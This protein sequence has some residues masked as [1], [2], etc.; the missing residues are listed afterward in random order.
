MNFEDWLNFWIKPTVRT[1]TIFQ[2]NNYSKLCKHKIKPEIC[3]RARSFTEPT[4]IIPEKPSS[5]AKSPL[6]LKFHVCESQTMARVNNCQVQTEIYLITS[7]KLSLHDFTHVRFMP[8][9]QPRKHDFI[10]L[11]S[12]CALSWLFKISICFYGFFC[13]NFDGKEQSM[14]L[15]NIQLVQVIK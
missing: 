7:K 8:V 11:A 9:H 14:W 2:Y 10:K 15:V 4:V 12:K 13:K 1:W 3:G 5:R 6:N